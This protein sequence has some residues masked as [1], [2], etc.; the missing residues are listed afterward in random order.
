MNQVNILQFDISKS[1]LW[2]SM[3]NVTFAVQPIILLLNAGRIERTFHFYSEGSNGY[4][5][6]LINRVDEER[7][8][9]A[10]KIGVENAL[11]TISI[12]K[13]MYGVDGLITHDTFLLCSLLFFCYIAFLYFYIRPV[14]FLCSL[15]R[16]HLG[17]LGHFYFRISLQT[18]PE[19]LNIVL[20]SHQSDF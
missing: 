1:Y 18:P 19:P 3:N 8:L 20:R 5:N 11:T 14:K 15:I 17:K 9:I 6:N 7:V 16:K 10:Q 2:S 13:Y 12:L 4:I